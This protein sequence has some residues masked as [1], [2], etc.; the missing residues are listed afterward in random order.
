MP[1]YSDTGPA[2]VRSAGGLKAVQASFARPSN[3]TPYVLNGLVGINTAVNAGNAI[4]VPNAVLNVGDVFRLDAVRMY[5]QVVSVLPSFRVWIWS[6]QPTFTVGD[7]GVFGSLTSLAT[8]NLDLLVDKVDVTLTMQGTG[9]GTGRGVPDLG[10]AIS[11]K[12]A[13][14]GFYISVTALSVYTPQSAENYTV[15]LEGVGQ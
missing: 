5:K 15:V 11:F 14:T 4:L 2:P 10:N 6:A 1:S 12:P 9:W 7:N 8:A 3:T 13:A